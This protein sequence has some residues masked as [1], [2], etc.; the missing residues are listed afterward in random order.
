[1]DQS[2]FLRG[3]VIESTYA[4][5]RRGGSDGNYGG[6][7]FVVEGCSD[8]ECF[9]FLPPHYELSASSSQFS[10]ALVAQWGQINPPPLLICL[11]SRVSYPERRRHSPPPLLPPLLVI[12]LRAHFIRSL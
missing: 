5:F 1:M 11:L 12:Y 4:S 7:G 9:Y 2:L 8:S 10:S 3:V 6:V